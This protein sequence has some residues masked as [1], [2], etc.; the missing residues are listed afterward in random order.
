[1]SEGNNGAGS[2]RAMRLNMAEVSVPLPHAL[3][4]PTVRLRL[5][6]AQILRLPRGEGKE[7]I[8][9]LLISRTKDAHLRLS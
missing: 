9:M 3:L 5:H 1:M 2:Q 8:L 4:M 6:P 7:L